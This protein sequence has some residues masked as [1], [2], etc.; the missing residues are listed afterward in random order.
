[1]SHWNPMGTDLARMHA[2]K[3]HIKAEQDRKQRERDM[4]HNIAEASKQYSRPKRLLYYP[5]RLF[6]WLR[7]G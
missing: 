4:H 2:N 1:M 7:G 5:V 6:R 3:Q